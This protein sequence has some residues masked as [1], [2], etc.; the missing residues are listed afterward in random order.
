MLEPL[1]VSSESA[2]DHPYRA[3]PPAAEPDG[4]RVPY[5]GQR[6][7]RLTLS[8]GLA[9]ARVV[10]DPEARDLLAID[11]G[12]G[13]RPQIHL[14]G[15]ELAVTWRRSFGDWLLLF[16]DWT[17]DLFT[18]GHGEVA[19]VLHPSV[20]WTI[21]IKGGLSKVAL[22]LS[23]GAIAQLDIAGGCNQVL[24]DLPPPTSVV[25]LHISGGALKLGVRRPAEAAVALGVTGGVAKLRLDDWS[26]EAIGGVANLTTGDLPPDAARYQLTIAGGACDLSIERR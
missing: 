15:D 11:H 2:P 5:G 25:P 23:A 18:S 24:I 7:M 19:I 26:F 17:R 8:A 12:F 16:G 3:A 10:I 1:H 13:P 4:M 20:E 21:E 9:N 6:R 22:E 14:A